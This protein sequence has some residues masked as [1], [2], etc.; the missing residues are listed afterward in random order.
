MRKLKK[1]RILHA[2]QVAAAA[3]LGALIVLGGIAL[4]SML[5]R[6]DPLN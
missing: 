2:V 4:S 3:I 6:G 5:M 1:M